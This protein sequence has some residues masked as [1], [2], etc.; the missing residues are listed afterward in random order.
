[1]G[2][3]DEEVVVPRDLEPSRVTAGHAPTLA[4][5][6]GR[7]QPEGLVAAGGMGMVFRARDEVLGRPVAVKV[8]REGRASDR[9][10]MERFRRE[11]RTA[12]AVDHPNVATVFDYG[13]EREQAF[14]VMELVEGE[15]LAERLRRGGR[16]PWR[17]ACRIG[18]Q[19]AAGLDAAHRQGLVHRD[20]K[21]GNILLARDGQVKLADFGIALSLEDTM[22]GRDRGL[23]TASYMAP[24]QARGGA[25]APATDLYSLG[26]VL[27][28][29]VTGRPPYTGSSP[30]AVAMQHLNAPVPDPR[31]L[32]PELPPE[33]VDLLVRGLQKEPAARFATAAELRERL[34]R[35]RQL[36]GGLPGPT[37]PEPALIDRL[38]RL[39]PPREPARPTGARRLARAVLAVV[40]VVVLLAGG[41]TA[42]RAVAAVDRGGGAVAT[43]RPPPGA[44]TTPG[45][46]V[47]PAQAPAAAGQTAAGGEQR[48]GPRGHHGRHDKHD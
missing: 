40:T 37:E 44:S 33:V 14:L 19:V 42:L 1:V 22:P 7:Y 30:I 23:G 25:T 3:A 18:E 47:G 29:A 41:V 15:T 16:L 34:A 46:A 17:E 12:A 39:A 11:A 20:I 43:A 48:H 8:M 4:K 21:P 26:C 10:F 38:L 45:A 32:L 35:A 27:F 31:A 6:A 2:A 28:E 24:E 36:P 5:L 13:E 9:A